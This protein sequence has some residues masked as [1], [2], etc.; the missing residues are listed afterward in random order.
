MLL[1]YFAVFYITG[2]LI[3]AFVVMLVAMFALRATRPRGPI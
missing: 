2:N 3:I 1:A